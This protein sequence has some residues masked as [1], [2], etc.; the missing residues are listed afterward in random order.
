MEI[1]IKGA[2][3]LLSLSIL[4]ILHEL[5]HFIPAKLFK[6]RVEKFYLFFNPWFSLFKF[7]K[8]ETEYGIGWLPLGGYV[9]ISGMIDESM[10]KEQMQQEPQEWEF[11]A[12]PAWQRLIIMVGGVTVN[13]LLAVVIYSSMLLVWGEEYLPTENLKYGISADSLG[14]A[15][16]FQSGDKI[17]SVGGVEVKNFQRV[18]AEIIMNEATTV[19]VERNGELMDVEINDEVFGKLLK[20]KGFLGIRF[21]FYADKFTAESAA[22]EAGVES[23][24]KLLG[25]NGDSLL[26]FDQ[27]RTYLANLKGQEAT[28]HV[29]R[30]GEILDIELTIP[31]TGLLGIFPQSDLTKFFELDKTEYNVVSA[32][33]AGVNKTFNTLTDYIKQLKLLFSPKV[34]AA[35]SLGGFITIGSI[36]PSEWD[37][38]NFWGLTAFLSVILAIMNILP[39]PALDGGHVMFLLYEVVTGRKPN[40]KFMEY[41]QYAGMALLLTLMLFANGNDVFKLFK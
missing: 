21:P 9:K 41:A 35:E 30:N 26:F 19:K 10:D 40:E 16:G 23:G 38:R 14:I 34:D 25:L 28:L 6:T 22:K 3:L 2:Q 1:F 15:A 33:P 8:G 24:D 18:T 13:M 27:Y 17:I 12:K 39:I 20:S 4:V 5:G 37:W 7:K 32:I 31:E 11:R 29:L 36:F